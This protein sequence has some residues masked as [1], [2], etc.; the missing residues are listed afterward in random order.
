MQITQAEKALR[1]QSLHQR[2]GVL[3]IANPWDAGSARILSALGFEALATSSFAMAG[4]HGRRD[5]G[6]T[7]EQALAHAASIVNATDLPVS[8]D[9]ENGFADSPAAIAE[10]IRLAAQAGLAGCSIEDHT[11]KKDQPLHE[12]AFAA[13]RIAAAAEAAHALPF[14]FTLTARA[15]NFFR[16]KPDL[17]DT[18]ARLAA[19]EKAG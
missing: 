8:A 7:R 11:G 3:L 17:D 12:I 18:I 6:I 4:T 13:E 19:Y 14:P 9:L 5:G 2:E 10:T 15:E 1:F 16:G